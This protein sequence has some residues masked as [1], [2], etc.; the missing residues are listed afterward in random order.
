MDHRAAG[1]DGVDPLHGVE[2]R[3]AIVRL[4]VEVALERADGLAAFA[5][6][7]V[8][9]RERLREADVGRPLVDRFLE[10]GAG[11]AEVVRAKQC[12]AEPLVDLREVGA[13]DER[14]LP[15]ARRLPIVSG[16]GKRRGHERQRRRRVALRLDGALEAQFGL[17]PLA[18]LEMDDPLIERRFDVRGDALAER[19]EGL[20]LDRS[21]GLELRFHHRIVHRQEQLGVHRR[22]AAEP[23]GRRQQDLGRGNL[24]AAG[25]RLDR[26]AFS[27]QDRAQDVLARRQLVRRHDLRED[28]A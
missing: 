10:D 25:Q 27:R 18:R 9:H 26:L 8:Q 24:E 6:G 22:L 1:V 16:R 7:T 5:E 14:R 3:L 23:V 20:L 19:R 15:G 11:L 21:L 13:A 17:R 4:L 2:I 12:V 28:D